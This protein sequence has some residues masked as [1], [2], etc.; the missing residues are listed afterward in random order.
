VRFDVENKTDNASV[1]NTDGVVVYPNP[2]SGML[3]LSEELS[4]V[5]LFDIAGRE[6]YAMSNMVNNIDLTN[7][8]K[9][10]YMLI[11][12]DGEKYISM[13]IVKK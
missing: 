3:Y 13:K 10:V 2:T 6:V 7:I 12:F 1:K 9:G 4:D 5:R 11:A 8:E